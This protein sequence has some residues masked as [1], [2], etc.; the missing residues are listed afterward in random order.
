[1]NIYAECFKKFNFE[2]KKCV[3]LRRNQLGIIFL[4]ICDTENKEEENCICILTPYLYSCC[5]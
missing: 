1:M 3:F 5:F 4:L 2:N